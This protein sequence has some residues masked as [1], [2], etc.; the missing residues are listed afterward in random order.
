MVDGEG[1]PKHG[2]NVF[3]GLERARSSFVAGPQRVFSGRVVS[4]Y[5]PSRGVRVG[6]SERTS[7]RE[8][9]PGEARDGLGDTRDVRIGVERSGQ[10]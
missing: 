9:V 5:P 8:E 7:V 2:Q 4:T 3:C 6:R 1:G 10:E